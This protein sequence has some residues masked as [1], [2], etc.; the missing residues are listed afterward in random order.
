MVWKRVYSRPVDK[1]TGLKCDQSIR[2]IIAQL[3][4]ERWKVELFFKWVKQHLRI[5]K[6][7]G[8]SRNA[9]YS[10]I[11]ICVCVYLFV[12]IVKKKLDVEHSLYTLLQIFSLTLFEKVPINE[13]LMNY[14]LQISTTEDAKQL[15]LFEL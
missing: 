14:P 4:K 12:A 2:L 6:F 5:K 13:L 3:Y 1:S 15:K 7:F 11:W 8:T 9:V 10:Q